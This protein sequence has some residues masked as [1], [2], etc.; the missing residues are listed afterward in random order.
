M[1]E[2][3][4]RPVY[5]HRAGRAGGVILPSREGIALS[6][7]DKPRN[8]EA[9]SRDGSEEPGFERQRQ[10]ADMKCTGGEM[11]GQELYGHAEV[12]LCFQLIGKEAL[13]QSG[14]KKR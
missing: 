13:G 2:Q 5:L 7:D 4:Q 8:R 12:L 10:S 9:M 14:E 1:A 6:G 11:P 3:R